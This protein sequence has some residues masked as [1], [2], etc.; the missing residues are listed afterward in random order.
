MSGAVV[1]KYVVEEYRPGME[2]AM[3]VCKEEFATRIDAEVRYP[4]MLFTQLT[5]EVY[6]ASGSV[7]NVHALHER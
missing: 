7:D 5:L 6:T 3:V 1:L 4:C 2:H